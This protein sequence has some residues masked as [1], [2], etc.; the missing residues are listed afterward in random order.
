MY[1]CV[2]VFGGGRPTSDTFNLKIKRAIP[3]AMTLILATN[4][5]VSTEDLKE[6][7]HERPYY[8]QILFPDATI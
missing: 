5:S 7:M 4:T 3:S 6:N 2:C 1:V 8:T